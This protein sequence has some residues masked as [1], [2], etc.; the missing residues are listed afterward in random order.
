MTNQLKIKT[1]DICVILHYMRH[2]T[3][4]SCLDIVNICFSLAL[5]ICLISFYMTHIIV[6]GVNL[7]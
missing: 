3:H 6:R 1:V 2:T 7:K 4:S 5:R